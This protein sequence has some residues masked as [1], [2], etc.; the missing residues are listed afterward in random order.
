MART[1]IPVDVFVAELVQLAVE[2]GAPYPYMSA[3]AAI[4]RQYEAA[5]AKN[6]HEDVVYLLEAGVALTR[7]EAKA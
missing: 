1:L 6:D 5:L 3:A 2:I 4:N 7:L